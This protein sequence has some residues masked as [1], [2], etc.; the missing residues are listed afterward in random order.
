ADAANVSCAW[1]LRRELFSWASTTAL[2]LDRDA[3]A[4]LSAPALLPDVANSISLA[5]IGV[6]MQNMLLRDT[7]F[8]SMAHSLEVR[9]P[10]LDHEVVELV[11]SFPGVWKRGTSPPKPL[12]VDAV[13]DLIPREV[14]ARPK[15]GFVLPYDH[16]LR[17]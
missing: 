14:Y 5:E 9:V 6:Y 17:S 4:S 15:M 2:M 1:S 11:A 10:L 13:S 8:M 12:L 16:W 7:D 3:V